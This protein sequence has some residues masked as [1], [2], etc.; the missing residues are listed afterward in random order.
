MV[1]ASSMGPSRSN[2]L[3]FSS[4][5]VGN[6]REWTG[7]VGSRAAKKPYKIT[8]IGS[9]RDSPEPPRS[10][11]N[12][13][14]PKR[15]DHARLGV[16]REARRETITWAPADPSH[17]S[18]TE[19][20]CAARDEDHLIPL[21]GAEVASGS[22]EPTREWFPPRPRYRTRYS[23]ATLSSKALGTAMRR[24][25][26]NV[27]PF[28]FARDR[29]GPLAESSNPVGAKLWPVFTSLF[30]CRRQ[31]VARD[32]GKRSRNRFAEQRIEPRGV[33]IL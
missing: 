14:G 28:V 17:G 22:I 30:H 7:S 21:R 15:L 19:V 6:G 26:Y 29:P 25:P 1:S 23:E 12:P 2:F 16:T 4:G 3:T 18:P 20:R 33:R 9:G 24:K 32:C 27:G 10:G 13:A 5:A 11:S 31:R 8:R